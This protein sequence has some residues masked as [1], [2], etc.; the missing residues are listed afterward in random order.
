MTKP[1]KKE[2]KKKPSL[3]HASTIGPLDSKR[4]KRPTDGPDL[5]RRQL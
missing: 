1:V 2:A 4:P 5:A 3:D